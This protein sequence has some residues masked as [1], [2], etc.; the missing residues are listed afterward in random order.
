MEIKEQLI[1][2][3]QIFCEIFLNSEVIVKNIIKPVVK[4]AKYS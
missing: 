1:T 2:L 3:L 4:F